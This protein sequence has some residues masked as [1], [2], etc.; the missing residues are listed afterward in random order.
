VTSD[1]TRDRGLTLVELIVVITVIG[2]IVLV[3]S[4]A[5]TVTLRQ[6][7]DTRGDVDVARWEQAL[8]LWL[9]PDIASAN[10][11]AFAAAFGDA[12]APTSAVLAP[13][14]CGSECG[15]SANALLLVWDD[16]GAQVQ[17]SYRYGPDPAEG[18]YVLTRVECRGASCSS[19]V[20]LRDLSPPEN[21]GTWAP[22]DGVPGEV[23]TVSGAVGGE[24]HAT[25]TVTVNGA[26]SVDGTDRS[27]T[28]SITA[29]GVEVDALETPSFEGPDFIDARSGCG[30]PV[31]LIVDESGSIGSADVDVRRGVESFVRA[32][33]GTDT[34]L[35]VLTMESTT[36]ALGTSGWSRFFDL[37]DPAEV[38][39][40]VGDA[41]VGSGG[42]LGQIDAGGGTDWEEALHRAYRDESGQTYAELGS[43]NRPEPELVVFFTDGLPT[44]WRSNVAVPPDYDVGAVDYDSDNGVGRTSHRLS[45]RAWYRADLVA[46]EIRGAGIRLIGVGVGSFD[47]A[48]HV[49][50][51]GVPGVTVWPGTS[52]WL[53]NAVFLG[54]LVS[55]V[56]RPPAFDGTTYQFD[57]VDRDPGSATSGDWEGVDDDTDVLTTSYMSALGDGLA[58]IALAE[59]GGTLTV[60]T[61][62]TAGATVDTDV[63]YTLDTG[64]DAKEQ[65]TTSRIDK[66][67]TFDV[68]LKGM[69][70]KEVELVPQ[71][72]D[73]TGLAAQSWMC[74]A[75]GV[76]LDSGSYST[77]DGD[78]AQGVR[79]TVRSDQAVS[80]TLTVS[81]S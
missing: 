55:G 63:T 59:C 38:D 62:D 49:G 36:R 77:I 72:L 60:Q 24:S 39:E 32:F 37:S 27:S 40:L 34:R 74:K 58:A 16:D 28:V 48:V 66:A 44:Q 56:A 17:V 65:A 13:S 20:V 8:A 10:P 15:G 12:T 78:A 68:P 45:K 73:G 9:P 19:R 76:E 67:A 29:G 31:T 14:G 79:V 53:D 50:N 61:R 26:P 5:A 33:E 7:G 23:M 35:Q 51:D 18:G 54:D 64:A 1:R 71:E 30:G 47:D 57:L 41:T 22:A 75:G 52:I 11:V 80:C 3:L 46:A 70:S 2:G 81:S 69:S 43:P 25:V 21:P 4:A 6:G 42:Y